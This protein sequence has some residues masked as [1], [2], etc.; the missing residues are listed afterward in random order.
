MKSVATGAA[1][2]TFGDGTTERAN[3]CVHLLGQPR[4]TLFGQP[5]R[6]SAPPRTLPLL[7]YLL[8]H[9]NAHLT[10]QSVALALWPDD[11][12]EAARTNLRRHLHH[13]K[14]ALPSLDTPWF[15]AD[16]ETLRWQADSQASFDVE[17]FE[18]RIA[19]G[20]LDE[21]VAIYAGDLLPSLYDDWIVADRERLRAL[22][23]GALET[24]LVRARSRRE[25]ALAS[26]YAHRILLEDPWREDTLRQLM[27][28]RYESG[29]RTGALRDFETFA[30]RLQSELNAEPMAETIALREIIL[31]SGSL[32]EHP[33]YSESPKP[34]RPAAGAHL[35]PF[36]GRGRE[37][38]H[39][40][41]AWERAARG[42]GSLLFL[43]GE[44]GI[45]KSRL[46]AELALF[47]SGQGARVLRGATS[48]VEEAPYQ[49]IREVLRDAAPLFDSLDIRPIWLSTISILIPT[50]ANQLGILPPPSLDP[51]RERE[52][53][54]EALAETFTS[55]SRQRPALV[56]LED[57]HWAGASSLAALEFVARRTREH[58]ALIVVTYRSEDVVVDHP[59]S[60]LRRRLSGEELAGHVAL[61]GLSADDVA[62]LV[63][64]VPGLADGTG[65]LAR[66]IANASG[67][68]PL[69]VGELLSHST[70]TRSQ[71]ELPRGISD[72]ILARSKLLST[73]GRL[74]AQIASVVG[75][76]FDV[77]SVREV[78]GYDENAVL[79][80]LGEL[81][82]RRM[83]RESTEPRSEF[84]FAHHVIQDA[85]YHSVDEKRR[86]RWHRRIASVL[87]RLPESE[88]L[89]SIG[90]LARH[91]DLSGDAATAATRY[92]T[93]AQRAS[94]LYA[95]EESVRHATRGLEL[96]TEDDIR[97]DLLMTRE[98]ANHFLNEP[99]A[100]GRDL[101]ELRK[102]ARVAMDGQA[103]CRVLE[104]TIKLSLDLNDRPLE[105]ESIELL[106]KKAN[107]I[108]DDYW[109][110][111]GYQRSA[112]HLW[113]T[114]QL[115]LS[116]ASNSRSAELF[117][118]IRD[119]HGR[120]T[121]ACLASVA[122]GQAGDFGRAADQIATASGIALFSG[123]PSM[124]ADA[125]RAR[126]TFALFR[127][128]VAAAQEAANELLQMSRSI[129]NRGLEIDAH[130]MLGS[131]AAVSWQ[132]EEA[133][134]HFE[135]ARGLGEMQANKHF[136][137][138][139][140][141]LSAN[142]AEELGKL[143]D[144]VLFARR[145]VALAEALRADAIRGQGLISLASV[146]LLRGEPTDC[147]Q[148]CTDALE[149]ARS[150][151][152]AQLASLMGKA[153][154]QL[155]DLGGAIELFEGAI[156]ELRSHGNFEPAFGAALSAA[157]TYLAAGQL[158]AAQRYVDELVRDME[159]FDLSFP[160]YV[161]PRVFWTAG[162]VL[163][164]TGKTEQAETMFK[165]ARAEFEEL[166]DA[167]PDAET[168]DCFS[169]LPHY[170]EILA[171][172]PL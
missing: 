52:R 169:A 106:L 21:A 20:E 79:D 46:A 65:A 23:N 113:S 148:L 59:L 127:C 90:L 86:V 15:V 10:R 99:V 22:Y 40:I 76:T 123:D 80:G 121:A 41:E 29:D 13:L 27:S 44:A 100:Q 35:L 112:I 48:P 36:V 77:E 104:R 130:Y 155:G 91:W 70:E 45:G 5:H 11:S 166:R 101:E 62:E 67:G 92:L 164:A 84:G 114:G 51:D 142:L 24:L 17:L 30:Q 108:D 39:L 147:M 14:E 132:V 53:L 71:S 105:I 107:S 64:V 26:D 116:S 115:A 168:R 170:Q 153:K 95:H 47:A 55:F 34:S 42:N 118:R 157:S 83:I 6:F 60:A 145:G 172:C 63:G 161:R 81:I 141:N 139:A 3:F 58:P 149:L 119:D 28:I 129:G 146:A 143:D 9:R 68:N 103:H 136:L 96:A 85:I 111:V 144:A 72:T 4:F 69:F 137:A 75:D 134:Q 32:P 117:E 31:R 140:L 19:A 57:L 82:D 43:S 7:A 33:H 12:E 2:A 25:F 1:R 125:A 122:A 159:S 94:S 8:L 74:L 110:A 93:A 102:S 152:A 154:A 49:A 150:R 61:E 135:D 56:V 16:G 120:F 18:R 167:I 78:S 37:L 88:R 73:T 162:R 66:T 171:Y 128:D 97:F 131:V 156:P 124:I 126:A 138:V 54:F 87:E 98:A 109:R 151:D 133:R 50:I 165:R 163:H 160:K 38:K 89:S 158:G